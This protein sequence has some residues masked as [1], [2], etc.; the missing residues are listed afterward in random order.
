MTKS[1]VKIINTDC[2]WC[3]VLWGVGIERN[4]TSSA[5]YT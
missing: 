4:G 5:Q 2:V 1:L 3:L